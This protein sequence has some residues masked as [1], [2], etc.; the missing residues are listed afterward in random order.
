MVK[1]LK[2]YLSDENLDD[3]ELLKIG[4]C[5]L[6]TV[7]GAYK[8]AHNKTFW[9]IN[10]FLQSLFY[11]F[12]DVPTRRGTYMRITKSYVFPLKFC[13]IRWSENFRVMEVAKIMLSCLKTYVQAVFKKPRSTENFTTVKDF[14][15]DKFL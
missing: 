12:R 13:C 10:K 14:L 9:S 7:N 4:T 8:T 6:H 11:L 15:Q 1:D 3:S 5:S 2:T